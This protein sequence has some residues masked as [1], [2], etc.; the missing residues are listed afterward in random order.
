MTPPYHG[1]DEDDMSAPL[2]DA[3][4]ILGHLQTFDWS[5]M[6]D[7]LTGISKWR[8]CCSKG[9]ITIQNVIR[10]PLKRCS[11]ANSGKCDEAEVKWW[12]EMEEWVWGEM[13]EVWSPSGCGDAIWPTEGRVQ[14]PGIGGVV[15]WLFW[16]RV[17]QA[18]YRT[19]KYTHWKS[20]TRIYTR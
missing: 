18:R 16:L 4:I 6:R 9:K 13:S 2:T 19:I 14:P 7:S 1:W 15:G 12:D 11:R 10:C 3:S 5:E 8:R 20:W 17:R